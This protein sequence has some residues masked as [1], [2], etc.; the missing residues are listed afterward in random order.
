M[1]DSNLE[2]YLRAAQKAG[3]PQDQ[4]LNFRRGGYV[5]QPKQLAF[6]AACRECDA[7]DGP[8][9]IGFGGARGGAKTH[10]AIAQM[11]LDDCQ[12]REGLK[13]LLLRRIGKAVRESFEDL[14]QKILSQT[15]H[16]YRRSDATLIFPNGSKVILGHYKDERDIDAYLGLEYDLVVVEEATTLPEDRYSSIRTCCRSSRPDWRARIY[17]NANPGGVGHAWYKA[18]FIVPALAGEETTRRFIFSTVQDNRYLSGDYRQ[19]LEDLTGWKK[20]AWLLGDWDIAAGQYFTTFNV[21]THVTPGFILPGHYKVWLTMDYGFALTHWNIIYLLA[22]DTHKNIYVVDELAHRKTLVPK[23]ANDLRQMLRRQG[24]LVPTRSLTFVMGSDAFTRR[25]TTATS[26]ADQWRKE[27]FRPKPANMDR[28]DGASELLR[29]LGDEKDNI[30]S[31]IEIFKNCKKLIDCIPSMEHD[32][33]RPDDV[34]KQIASESGTGGDDP[35]DAV[36]YG[37][38]EVYPGNRPS[39]GKSPVTNWRG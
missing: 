35:Y 36:R 5:A 16:K 39:V 32:P 24:I 22:Q 33:H 12:R 15:P 13:A 27:G 18:R 3:C 7:P 17:S 8:V 14:R 37:I 21:L 20:R 34:L 1:I 38:M 23:I 19:V 30:P 6:H 28:I 2:R 29:L 10:G 11:T 26:I 25:G 9:E 4:I 31:S